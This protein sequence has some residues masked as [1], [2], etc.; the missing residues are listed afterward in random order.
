VGGTQ[1]PAPEG[2]HKRSLV[3]ALTNWKSPFPLVVA[4]SGRG[5]W[6]SP[7]PRVAS[8]SA[9]PHPG[10]FLCGASRRVSLRRNCV[11]PVLTRKNFGQGLCHALTGLDDGV[12]P[13]PGRCPGLV[14]RA[15]SGLIPTS[16]IRPIRPI[17][18]IR[19]IR[20]IR[21]IRPICCPCPVR[22]KSVSRPCKVR[23]PS[24]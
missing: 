9:L 3:E 1:E 8:R 2:R 7:L 20:L 15:P 13:D 23:V 4:P 24:V 19:L 5:F 16:P 17:Y 11:K 10:L 12:I 21:P 22:G 14:C 18:L 6:G